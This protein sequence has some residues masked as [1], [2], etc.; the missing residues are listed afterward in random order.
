MLRAVGEGINL[1]SNHIISLVIKY[2][3]SNAFSNL[4]KETSTKGMQKNG[5]KEDVTKYFDLLMAYESTK[6]HRKQAATA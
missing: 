4:W 2:E 3:E 1:Q 6:T 5:K